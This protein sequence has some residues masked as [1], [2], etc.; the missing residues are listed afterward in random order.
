MTK[1]IHQQMKSKGRM[2]IDY[3]PVPAHKLPTFFRAITS[4]YR[5]THEILKQMLIDIMLSA[6]ELNIN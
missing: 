3:S 4:N 6:Q 2:A 1:K 5:L